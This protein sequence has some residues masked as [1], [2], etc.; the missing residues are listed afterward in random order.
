[1]LKVYKSLALGELQEE[2]R[3]KS[4]TLIVLTDPD[5]EKIKQV[6]S[7]F[8]LPEKFFTDSLDPQE[9]PRLERDSN[10]LLIVLNIPVTN[11]NAGKENEAPYI[12]L[13]FG[14][15]HAENNLFLVTKKAHQPLIDQFLNGQF[16]LFETHM[17]TRMT[18]LLFKAVA[19]SYD[20][21]L[22]FVKDE[23]R[24]LQ[25]KLRQSYQNR[26]LFSLINQNKSLLQ[27]SVALSALTILYRQVINGYAVKIYPEEKGLLS[28]ILV[29]IEQSAEVAEM[30]RESLSNLMDAY[31]AIVHNNLNTVLKTLTALAIILIIPSM[32]GSIFSM[33]VALPS[34]EDPISTVV[35][36]SIMVLVSVIL[37]FFFYCKKYIR[38]D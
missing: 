12:T 26:E 18:I 6:A 32:I 21:H 7:Q 10:G 29:D 35:V 27:F 28:D 33:N 24:V 22:G 17:K 9:H 31:A 14:I 3:F 25:Q 1:M 23:T 5:S 11:P 13:P 8:K 16:G 36:A 37:L 34:E 19:K 30:S 2:A 38:F 15:I 20:D 4:N